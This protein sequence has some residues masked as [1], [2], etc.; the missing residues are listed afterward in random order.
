MP[1]D[2]TVFLIMIFI[3]VFMLALTVIVPSFGTDA[4]AAKRMRARIKD[5]M[6]SLDA[7]GA[8]LLQEKYRKEMTSTEKLLTKIP[9][10]QTI[11]DWN[12]QAGH[13]YSLSKIISISIALSVVGFLISYFF[14][15][16]TSLALGI[17][18]GGFLLPILKIKRDRNK[19]LN[20]FEEQLP[21]ALDIMSRAMKA[22]HPFVDTLKYVGEELSNPIAKEFSH[23]FSDINYGVDLKAAFMELLR[24]VPSVSLLTVVTAVLIQKTSGGN[25]TEILDKIASIV[26]GR[27]RF[28]R[29]LR[30]LSA[31]G[32]LSAW[33]LTLV[34]FF[35]TAGLWLAA[36]EYIEMLFRED[37]GKKLVLFAFIW[38]MIGALIIRRII[39]IDV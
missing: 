6:S 23:T 3:A 16:N 9:G 20:L 8:R 24:R 14:T 5:V 30:T 35:M 1:A 37:F 27:F 15:Y 18:A 25:M 32:R 29:K 26:R 12:E 36:P 11:S 21:E 22:G 4:K 7:D 13:S 39:R 2:I 34:P 10:M 33:I 28:E 19:R 38:M 17:G 31:E